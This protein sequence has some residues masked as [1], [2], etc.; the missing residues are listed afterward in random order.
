MNAVNLIPAEGRRRASLPTSRPTLALLG[1]LVV[2]LVAAYLYV[3]AANQVTARRA[4]LAQTTTAA[5]DWNA[6][7]TTVA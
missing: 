5:N 7:S 6:A 3:S 1:G 4:Q 2:A